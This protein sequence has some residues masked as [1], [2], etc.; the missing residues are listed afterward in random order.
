[1]D[2]KQ[3]SK[4]IIKNIGGV[5]NV[6]ALT[7]CATRL[8]FN[9]K[10]DN[11]AA[12]DILKNTKGIMGVVNKGGQYQVII[13]SDV[14]NVYAEINKIASFDNDSSSEIKNDK[15]PVVKVL[16]T[17]AGIFTPIIPAITGAGML[18]AVMALLVAFKVI[19][20]QTQVYSILNF[21]ADAAF[22]FLP[23][24]IANSAAKKFKCNPYMAMSIAAIILHPNFIGMVDAAKKGGTGIYFLGLP[25]TLASY[26]SSVIPIILGVWFMSFVEPIADKVSPNA[27]KFFTKP[28]LTLLITGLVTLIV[29]G[30]IGI[31]C[32][33]GISGAIAF[34]NTY[35][36]W[37]VPLIVGTFSPLLVMTGMHYGLIPIGINNLATAGFDIVVGPGMLGSNI[38]QGGA[39]LAVALKTKSSELKQ[40]ASSAGITAVCGITEPAMYGVTLKLKRPLIAV[41]IGG[42]AS[43]LF[44]GITGVGR[45]TAGSPGL[46]ALPGYIGTEGFRNITLACIG[47]AIAFVVSFVA[48]LIIGFEDIAEVKENDSK[49]EVAVDENDDVQDS[50]AYSPIEGKAVSLSK[51]NDPMFSEK[52]MGDGIAIIPKEGRVVSPVNGK[53]SA[54]FETKHAIGIISNE[55]A[56][57]LIHI[58]LDTVK[59]NGKFFEAKVKEGDSINIGDLLVKFNLEEIKK[60]GYD[61]ITPIII[62]NTSKYREITFDVN[63]GE[64]IRE[65]DKL[66]NLIK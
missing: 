63:E 17:I 45:Y 25:V 52:M 4:D 14:A 10:D 22:Y 39:A 28:L 59:L 57:I 31:I 9:L 12:T 19:G 41:M 18:K 32:G 34:I 37:L 55:G 53:V 62:T 35:A 8:R 49:T 27:I 13:G 20:N 38:A 23:F 66:I 15:G 51:V 2:Y 50:I 16:D 29:L 24:L 42:G 65:K 54:V 26:S 33:N 7:H 58:G 40:L 56:E 43:G 46:L 11:K 48:T 44:L 30:P 6:S 3:L 64:D 21:M 5:E 61:V 1:M 60:A 36:R 47:A